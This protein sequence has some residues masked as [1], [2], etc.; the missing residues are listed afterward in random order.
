METRE[1]LRRL[2]QSKHWRPMPGMLNIYGDRIVGIAPAEGDYEDGG[3]WRVSG[4][5]QV[6]YHGGD[7]VQGMHPSDF[8]PDLS[9]P[10]T[11]GCVLEL[12]R[13][14]L[15]PCY[16]RRDGAYTYRIICPSPNAHLGLA[17][18]LTEADAILGAFPD[19]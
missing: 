15:G 7:G 18:Y 4:K 10:A 3:L 14:A 2:L 8:V 19:A 11:R 16:V 5:L 1:K 13:E 17:S 6:V 12:M 9:D